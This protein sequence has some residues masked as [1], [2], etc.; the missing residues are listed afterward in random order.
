MNFADF[1]KTIGR[2][3]RGGAVNRFTP[4]EVRGRVY[5]THEKGKI[6]QGYV[7]LYVSIDKQLADFTKCYRPRFAPNIDNAI[8][9][10]PDAKGWKFTTSAKESLSAKVRFD[11]LLTDLPTQ[12]LVALKTSDKN[13]VQLNGEYID[14]HFLLT[15][16]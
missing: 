14:D 10:A 4:G 16:K 5:F 8:L 3:G 15:L 12:I 6:R 1:T 2:N 7:T 13:L 9:I 11:F